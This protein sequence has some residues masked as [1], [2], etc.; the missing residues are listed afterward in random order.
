M[1]EALSSAPISEDHRTLM[2]AVLQ[3][4]QSIDSGLK[5]AFNGLLTGFKVSHVILFF[6][7]KVNLPS[8][9]NPY[10]CSS[11]RALGEFE[12][13]TRGSNVRKLVTML[14][15]PFVPHY[16]KSSGEYLA[17]GLNPTAREF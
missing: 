9:C 17:E 15:A 12:K 11:P 10:K 4:I 7:E 8:L 1:E 5:E 2:G 3:G 14:K 6:P 13:P 16:S